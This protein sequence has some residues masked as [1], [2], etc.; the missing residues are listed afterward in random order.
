MAL[1]DTMR[2]NYLILFLWCIACWLNVPCECTPGTT[3]YSSS[4]TIDDK[5]H[6]ERIVMTKKPGEK[7]CTT[8]YE[9]F[10]CPKDLK[11][12]SR[13]NRIININN[14]Q[15]SLSNV[16][17]FFTLL[18]TFQCHPCGK[19]SQRGFIFNYSDNFNGL[20]APQRIFNIPQ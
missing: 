11:S 3:I 8:V 17:W 7:Y 16:I 9:K 5:G 10:N 18:F 13:G 12:K 4:C 19:D 2:I 6:G 1:A 14:S 20:P 15:C